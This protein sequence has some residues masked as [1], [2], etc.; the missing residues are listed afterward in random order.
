MHRW[1]NKGLPNKKIRCVRTT[2]MARSTSSHVRPDRLARTK[3]TIPFEFP[4]NARPV[5]GFRSNSLATH[6]RSIDAVHD[7]GQATRFHYFVMSPP[8]PLILSY[9]SERSLTSLNCFRLSANALHR[10]DAA[11]CAVHSIKG[12][13][14]A[15]S[16]YVQPMAGIQRPVGGAMSRVVQARP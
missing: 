13:H 11:E 16:V 12:R 14:R 1:P 9:L 2:M 3:M 10:S 8:T 7:L 15:T 4:C 6:G 5:H